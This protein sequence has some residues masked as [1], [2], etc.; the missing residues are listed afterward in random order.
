[1]ILFIFLIVIIF[2]IITLSLIAAM[3]SFDNNLTMLLGEKAALQGRH[4]GLQQLQKLPEPVRKY[5]ENI[6]HDGQPYI[7]FVRLKHDGRFR[8]GINGDWIPITGEEYFN[9]RHPGFL[10]RGRTKFFTAVDSYIGRTGNLKVYLFSFMRIINSSGPKISQGELLR[11]LGESVW[12][13]TALLPDEHLHWE[14]IDAHHAL[15]ICT[16]A[17]LMVYYTVTFN[18]MF[19]ISM[20]ETSRFKGNGQQEHWIGQLSEYKRINN[21]SIPTRIKATWQLFEGSFE[22][23]DFTLKEIAYDVPAK[24]KN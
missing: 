9:A 11:W 10:W 19:E 16:Y 4:Y 1:M 18:Q 6:L 14:P 17:N 24:F 23:A 3:N 13:P 15:V 2:F 22:Y 21:V 20:L 5:F 12:F 7:H 8:T